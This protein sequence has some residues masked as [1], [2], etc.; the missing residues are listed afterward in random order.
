MSKI[1][2]YTI[3]CPKCHV[4]E[5]KLQDKSVNFERVSDIEVLKEKGFNLFPKLE[6]D[7]R[8]M[9]FKEAVDWVNGV[10]MNGNSN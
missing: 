4:L 1:I 7:G 9:E 8:I 5:K 6:I 2:L 3:D 10:I